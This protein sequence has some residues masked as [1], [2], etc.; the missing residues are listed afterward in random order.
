MFNVFLNLPD[1]TA[2]TSTES[3]NFVGTVTVLAKTKSPIARAP[4][5]TNAAFDVTDVLSKLTGAENLSVT[6]AP[7]AAGGIAPTASQATFRQI[8]LERF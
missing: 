4:V 6:L 7:A 8:S 2:A 1:A 3:P 5:T